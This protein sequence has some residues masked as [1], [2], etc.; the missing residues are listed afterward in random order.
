VTATWRPVV[1]HEGLYEVSDEGDV[2]SLLKA[3][4][5]VLVGQR[6]PRTGHLH[7]TLYKNAVA[8]PAYIHRLAA[9]AFIGEPTGPMVRHLDDVPTN[10]HAS[11]LAYG[12]AADNAQDMLRNKGHRGNR[13]TECHNGHAFTPENIRIS[14]GSRNCIECNRAAVLRYTAR[15]RARSI[16]ASG[17]AA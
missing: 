15:K 1:G 6:H 4:P 14:N 13:M 11:N 9:R 5:R 2:R 10:N 12:T 7:V 16:S 17:R 8:T 3:K